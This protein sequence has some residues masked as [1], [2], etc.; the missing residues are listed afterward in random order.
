MPKRSWCWKFYDKTYEKKFEVLLET[1]AGE[2]TSE[3]LNSFWETYLSPQNPEDY[4]KTA[5]NDFFTCPLTGNMVKIKELVC[6]EDHN[7]N[8]QCKNGEC[9]KRVKEIIPSEWWKK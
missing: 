4:G 2:S 5:L 9:F 3:K 1:L 8:F 7:P 6:V